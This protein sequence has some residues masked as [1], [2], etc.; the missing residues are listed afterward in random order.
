[1][2]EPDLRVIQVGIGGFGS[3]WARIANETTGIELAAVVD[4]AAAARRWANGELGLASNQIFAALHD[5]LESVDSEAVLVITPPATHH[6]VATAALRAGKHVLVEKPLATTITE[7]KDLIATAEYQE[8]TLVVSQ[9]YRYR[10]PARTIQEL[11]ASGRLGELLSIDVAFRR[12]TR[13]IW[14]PDNFRYQMRHPTVLDMSIHHLDLLRAITGRNIARIDAR[15]WPVPDSPYQHDPTV[16]AL[17]DLEGGVPVT[18]HGDWATHGTDTSWNGDWVLTGSRGR[19]EWTSD[20]D[21]PLVGRALLTPWDG[22]P[23]EL[24]QRALGAVDRVGSLLAFRRAV[25]TGE[26]AETRA[27]DNIWS[28]AAV[29]A[30]VESIERKEPVQI[31]A[32]IE[33]G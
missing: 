18:Y 26:P 31:S 21:N 12:D 27:E 11:I 32:L 10:N 1:M 14:P 22:E 8:R 4:P 9:N 15:S 5:A 17:I 6:Q 3:S 23:M 24:E 29:N 7:A 30:C 28:L 19:I 13:T 20:V 16:S 2:V 25:L 33:R